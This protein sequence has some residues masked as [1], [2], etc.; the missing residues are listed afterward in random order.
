MK[1]WYIE[2]GPESDV[3]MSS[4]V[5]LARNFKDFPFPFRMKRED[6]EKVLK[7]VKDV[8][9]E[10]GSDIGRFDFENIQKLSPL[11]R[12][13]LVEKHLMS[14][15]LADSN[16]ESGIIISSDERASIMIN[17]EDHLRIQCLFPGM[18]L[19]NA[20][21]LC[22]SIDNLFEENVDFAFE[23][24]FGYLTS[25]PTNVGTGIRASAMLHLPALTMTGH[26][27]GI[28]EVC[29]KLGIT[30][31]GIYGE[32]SEAS[33]NMFQISNQVT[34]GQT[35]EEIITNIKNIA[36]QVIDQ[37]RMLRKE[38]YRQNPFRFED[39]IYRAL[40]ILSN[41]RIVSSEESFKL[42]SDVR[43]GVDMGIISN[44]D[45]NNLNEIFI[46]IQPANLQQS[47]GRQLLSGERD[48]KRAEL[49]RNRLK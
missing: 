14:T 26:V 23:E 2:K 38:L 36:K 13:I 15:E 43:L 19:D 6:G 4:R 46:S 9:L 24:N 25:C 44:I 41:A 37:E 12:Q 5:R 48:V 49:I 22:N 17:E 1:G 20:W 30:V 42:L 7:K 16:M 40:G 47:V 27:K 11:S 32:N 34:L 45:I 10:K 18:Q 31:R 35:E 8:I 29:G 3:V 21:N 33:G 39:R 28:L